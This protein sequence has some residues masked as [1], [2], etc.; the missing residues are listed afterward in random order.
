MP[1]N[2]N[3]HNNNFC[4]V[5]N[6]YEDKI[7]EPAKLIAGESGLSREVSWF[8]VIEVLDDFSIFHGNEI[9]LTTFFNI[10]DNQDQQSSLLINLNEKN[11]AAL[12]IITGDYVNNI[13]KKLIETANKLCLPVFWLDFYEDINLLTK[14]L[15]RY[16]INFNQKWELEDRI[17]KK[18]IH[19]KGIS[20]IEFG[21]LTPRDKT[22][23]LIFLIK[24]Q[25]SNYSSQDDYINPQIDF[26][27]FVNKL[28]DFLLEYFGHSV[29]IQ[30]KN[31][32]TTFLAYYK[33]TFTNDIWSWSKTLAENI[34]KKFK[35]IELKIGISYPFEDFSDISNHIEEPDI[36]IN[37]LEKIEPNEKIF[38]FYDCLVYYLISNINNKN[39]I[40]KYLFNMFEPISITDKEFKQNLLFTLRSYINSDCNI[41]KASENIHVH[42]NTLY[43]RLNKINENFF[44][45]Q[46]FSFYDKFLIYLFFM[47]NDLMG[48]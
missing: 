18:L 41:I 23:K 10:G 38:C 11:I 9:I 5:S 3:Y 44:I 21:N 8:H 25:N 12:V 6:L 33:D 27:K 4:K 42:R 1:I 47:L 45:K 19:N 46:P 34:I 7:F 30:L 15:S 13:S 37:I 16:I 17:F 32:N 35:F 14:K 31:L 24:T 26:N 2:N 36:A 43:Y 48:K 22:K 29:P 28:S 20:N 40:N 39:I